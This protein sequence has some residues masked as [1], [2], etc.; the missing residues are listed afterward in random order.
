M[1]DVQLSGPDLTQGVALADLPDNGLLGGHANGKPVLMSREGTTVWAVDGA[2]THYSGP[3]AEGLKTGHTV[4]CPW[5][6]ACFDLRTGEATA[7]PALRPLAQWKVEQRDDRVFVRDELA[8]SPR[9]RS[10]REKPASVVI[11]GAGAAGD[12]AADMLR[13]EGYDGSITMIGED[14]SPPVDRP[15]LSKDYLAG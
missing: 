7:A 12:A 13:R 14:D 3:L 5:H 2:C 1:G 4:R 9:R 11:I 6:H 10:P 15:N 8:T